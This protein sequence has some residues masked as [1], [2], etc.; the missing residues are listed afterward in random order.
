LFPLAAPALLRIFSFQRDAGHRARR[1]LEQRARAAR[2]D[3]AVRAG[4]HGSR[5]G[6]DGLAP[7]DARALF[8]LAGHDPRYGLHREPCRAHLGSRTDL[9]AGGRRAPGRSRAAHCLLFGAEQ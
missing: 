2:R 5:G 6:R 8:G 7:P 4:P 3:V 9:G 1:S